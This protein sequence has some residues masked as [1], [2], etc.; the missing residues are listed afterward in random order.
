MVQNESEK[1]IFYFQ[2]ENQAKA[3]QRKV[4]QIMARLALGQKHQFIVD[5]ESASSKT[6]SR[7]RLATQRC[8][9]A[10]CQRFLEWVG[11]IEIDGKT[12]WPDEILRRLRP[13]DYIH[14]L[15]NLLGSPPGGARK[16]GT[17]EMA[18]EFVRNLPLP[19]P[20][21]DVEWLADIIRLTAQESDPNQVYLKLL[22][23]ELPKYYEPL[24]NKHPM[25]LEASKTLENYSVMVQLK[26]FVRDVDGYVRASAKLVGS[27]YSECVAEIGQHVYEDIGPERARSH[28]EQNGWHFVFAIYSDAL[29]WLSGK[30]LREVSAQ[31]YFVKGSRL[32]RTRSRLAWLCGEA[33]TLFQAPLIGL[34]ELPR[35]EQIDML[36]KIHLRLRNKYRGNK[37]AQ[38]LA[39]TITNLRIT[40]ANL[41]EVLRHFACT[42]TPS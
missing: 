3:R 40:R 34:F 24:W 15:E 2:A 28:L 38:A 25:F 36:V 22:R 4:A 16:G 30:Y 19:E 10:Q 20:D 37:E 8:D 7:V 1:R 11:K 31:D 21:Y 33:H 9:Y 23:G 27:I 18:V 5:S 29:R 12:V 26:D 14:R 42:A 13:Q 41:A 35:R 32:R 17:M 6:I 39:R